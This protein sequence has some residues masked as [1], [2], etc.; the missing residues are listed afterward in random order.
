MLGSLREFRQMAHV[1]A[2]ISHDHMATAFH[3]FISNL[4][5]FPPVVAE[6]EAALGYTWSGV[7]GVSEYPYESK[8]RQTL[9]TQST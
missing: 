1:S 6:D 8:F 3:F 4:G 5:M 7:V 9:V 2:Q